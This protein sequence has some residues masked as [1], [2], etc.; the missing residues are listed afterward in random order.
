M[1]YTV[2]EHELE[3]REDAIV[4]EADTPTAAVEKWAQK[5]D[6]GNDDFSTEVLVIDENGSS[7]RFAVT[8]EVSMTYHTTEKAS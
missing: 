6:Y 8:G 3:E 7:T 1:N 2:W 5:A 4:V